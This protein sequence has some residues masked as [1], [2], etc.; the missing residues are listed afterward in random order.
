MILYIRQLRSRNKNQFI[1]SHAD[2]ARLRIEPTSPAAWASA[3]SQNSWRFL[4]PFSQTQWV[5]LRHLTFLRGIA[6]PKLFLRNQKPI[7]SCS[8]KT[9]WRV[10][11][12]KLDSIFVSQALDLKSCKKSKN[13][14]VKGSKA[15]VLDVWLKLRFKAIQGL[16]NFQLPFIRYVQRNGL[17]LCLEGLWFL[18]RQAEIK[19][20]D[21]LT[22]CT[23]AG[24]R[25]WNFLCST[26]HS[27][28]I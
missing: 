9:R 15:L 21:L 1:K 7:K 13:R 22:R 17:C 3:R 24:E 16:G 11:F 10:I 6:K 27:T 4:F 20:A 23:K 19:I 2:Q 12:Y 18:L 8:F 28:Q 14:M 25:L 26:P 5:E